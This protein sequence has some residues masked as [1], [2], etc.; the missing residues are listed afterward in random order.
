MSRTSPDKI[1]DSSAYLL[2]YRRRSELPLGGPR[3]KEIIENL[4]HPAA[5]EEI[6]EAGEGQ[7]L[8]EGSSQT[9]S[10]S[11]FQE[12]EA[13]VTHRRRLGTGGNG[14]VVTDTQ[15]DDDLPSLSRINF[16]SQAVQPSIEDEGIDVTDKPTHTSLTSD[17]NFDSLLT[18][19]HMNP[20]Q[21]SGVPGSP[22]GS[23]ATN[24]AQHDS[25]GDEQ[26]HS[27]RNA[28]SPE[29]DMDIPGASHYEL[30]P[31]TEGEP[32]AYTELPP[33]DSRAEIDRE[34]MNR[35][36]DNKQN[37]LNVP[38]PGGDSHSEEAA[39]IHL[40]GNDRNKMD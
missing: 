34:D 39:E 15:S 30:G 22:A 3:F 9:G 31:S 16:D 13:A 18:A 23:M 21:D 29:T 1:V 40:D 19:E 37:I 27:S 8:G 14:G 17:W 20:G 32:P 6:D 25:S 38:V 36:W 24:E 33:P 7:R 11:A 35:I 4:D 12:Q 10:P 2:F 5:G 26:L 28:F